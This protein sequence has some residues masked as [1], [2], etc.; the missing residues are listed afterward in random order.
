MD[1]RAELK[2]LT[3]A[4]GFYWRAGDDDSWLAIVG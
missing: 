4:V 3:L 1:R 2:A